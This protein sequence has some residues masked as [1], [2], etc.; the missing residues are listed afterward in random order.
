MQAGQFSPAIFNLTGNSYKSPVKQ[1]P[2]RLS[3]RMSQATF[4]YK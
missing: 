3:A 2:L 4:F 1:K